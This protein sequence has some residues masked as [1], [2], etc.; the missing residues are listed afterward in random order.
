[1][2]IT[3]VQNTQELQAFL[4]KD[5]YEFR[6]A[7]GYTKP[8]ANLTTSNI[9]EIVL[10]LALHLNIYSNKAEFDQISEGL[11]LEGLIWIENEVNSLTGVFIQKSDVVCESCTFTVQP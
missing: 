2:K 6:Y 7:C 10:C 9:K 4:M 5:E 3:E 11:K 1:M 8:V